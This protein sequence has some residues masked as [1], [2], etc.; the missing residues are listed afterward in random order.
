M[1]KSLLKRAA[2]F[3][4]ASAVA[5]SA[6][7]SAYATDIII[8]PGTHSKTGDDDRYYAYQI[9]AGSVGGTKDGDY[10]DNHT[11]DFDN[12]YKAFEGLLDNAEDVAAFGSAVE[13]AVSDGA[14]QGATDEQKALADYVKSLFDKYTST[15]P[16]ADPDT[17][18]EAW[19]TDY[20]NGVE[21]A[22]EALE[23]AY[24]AD[25]DS[26]HTM[27][28]I[29]WGKALITYATTP[30]ETPHASYANIEALLKAL[31]E[32]DWTGKSGAAD[33]KTAFVKIYNDFKAAYG[34]AETDPGKLA[35]L[36]RESRSDALSVAK[37][38]AGTYK[39]ADNR[40]ISSDNINT[41]FLQRFAAVVYGVLDAK[42]AVG[43]PAKWFGGEDEQY[44]K[45]TGVDEGYYLIADTKVLDADDEDDVRAPYF[46]DVITGQDVTIKL[47]SDAPTLDK[48]IENVNGSD[49][50][51]DAK[52]DTA[53]AKIGDTVSYKLVGTLPENFGQ[54]YSAYV[55]KFTDTMDKSL[56]YKAN[57]AKVTI[58]GVNGDIEVNADNFPDTMFADSKTLDDY[59]KIVAKTYAASVEEDGKRDGNETDDTIYTA[60]EAN[61]G[62]TRLTV[63]FTD[64]Y[65]L[66][67][68]YAAAT[69]DVVFDDIDWTKVTVIVE[70]D[71]VLNAEAVIGG[72]GNKN[73]ADLEYSNDPNYDG[74]GTT[75]P[76][77]TT[78]TTT[79]TPDDATVYTY[80]FEL[81]K[82]DPSG[83]ILP[84]AKFIVSGQGSNPGVF[85]KTGDGVYTYVGTAHVTDPDSE[86]DVNSLIY[87]EFIKN[88]GEDLKLVIGE[89]AYNELTSADLITEI[90]VG[91]NGTLV[92]N[93]IN[94]ATWFLTETFAPDGFEKAISFFLAVK[95]EVSWTET[96][97]S[98]SAPVNTTKSG[99]KDMY[100]AVITSATLTKS[101]YKYTGVLY[102]EYNS[103][104][105]KYT[106]DPKGTNITVRNSDK[107][108][109]DL[110]TFGG[111]TTD[112]AH[113]KFM[114]TDPFETNNL[115]GTGGMGVYFYYIV[116]GVLIALAGAALFLTRKKSDKRS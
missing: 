53:N 9:F 80:G 32:E 34:A 77:S 11:H 70:Y 15:T 91:T 35:D 27:T 63:E 38:L 3:V 94:E 21:A 83:N 45:V 116:G 114:V 92:V 106:N 8:E 68:A 20:G 51:V 7:V 67:K 97:T 111:L 86:M 57:S 84:G 87:A 43:T 78:T 81:E 48:T 50:T 17:G 103:A 108:K 6:A 16:D 85:I 75:P 42:S 30:D 101:D 66:L 107:E 26:R 40:T 18:Y 59:M 37:V 82:R 10:S 109:A 46:V 112:K 88:H 73:V 13:K 99:S 96:D 4:L 110:I 41:A 89:D 61:I 113:A 95:A 64:L 54:F 76:P 36:Y 25:W 56:T 74:D 104:D 52:G 55:Y 33:F 47:K 90:T 58:K 1:K 5:V 2:S 31:S 93:G 69:A 102:A 44:W 100:D 115:P 72:R 28:D 19:A 79:T 65:T 22:V 71:A 29:L 24:K 98:G 39:L 62:K 14:A 49:N 105:G 12:V 60:T 23:R